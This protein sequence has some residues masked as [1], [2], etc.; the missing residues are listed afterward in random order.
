MKKLKTKITVAG[1]VALTV[2]FCALAQTG[3]ETNS[4]AVAAGDQPD[5]A[6][7][8]TFIELARSDLKTQKALVIAENLPMAEAEAAEFWPLHREYEAELTKVNDQ[9]LA[10]IVRYAKLHNTGTITDQEATK[11]A[12]DSFDLET[13]RTDLKRKYFKKFAKV[14]PATTATRFFQIENQINLALDLRVAASLPLIK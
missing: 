10:L 13:K 8:R 5:A 2:A 14:M 3:G 9:K 1:A 7:L 11:L 4:V 12:K 6:N